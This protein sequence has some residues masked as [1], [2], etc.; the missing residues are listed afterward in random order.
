VKISEW[1][2]EESEKIGILALTKKIFGEHEITQESYFDW[3][4]R[5]NPQGN[6]LVLLAKDEKKEGT[7]IGC[8]ILIPIDLIVNEKIIRSSLACNV[9]VDPDYRNQGIFSKLLIS[10][11]E[12][13]KRNNISCLYAIPNDKSFNA[14]VK[15]GSVKIISLPLLVRPLKFSG[16]FNSS[17]RWIFKLIDWIWKINKVEN[18]EIKL[19]EGDFSMEF[20]NLCNK[21]TGRIP[22]MIRR[23]V[24]FLRWRYSECP[25]RKYRIFTL[26]EDSTLKAYII[27]RITKFEGKTIGIIVDFLVDD[28]IE[29]KKKIKDLVNIALLDLMQ[30]GASVA[31]ATCNE[32]FLE[33]TILH[34]SRFFSIP[35]YFKPRQLHFITSS[36]VEDNSLKKLEN[37]DNW[38]FSFG[39]YDVF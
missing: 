28:K 10:M 6:A 14:F 11:K 7:I 20:E 35:N 1:I 8:N 22:I 17:L 26:H 30:N 4:Y 38:F 13:A 18:N 33:N 34:K 37:Y 21:A 27:T 16:L 31:I 32:R 24:N 36:F 5:K 23:N 19:F 29:N 2:D 39:D 3:Q 15:Q 12:Y 9:Q 25:T